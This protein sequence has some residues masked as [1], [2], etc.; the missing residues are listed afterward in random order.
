MSLTELATKIFDDLGAP[1]DTSEAAILSWL[2]TSLGKLN[3][4][5][6][7]DYVVEGGDASP[8]LGDEEAMLYQSVYLIAYYQRQ[9]SKNLGAAAYVS[10]AEVKE[11]NRTVRRTNRTEIAKTYRG[12][13]ADTQQDLSMALLAYKM[14]RS[15]P[16]DVYVSN[17]VVDESINLP[18]NVTE[19]GGN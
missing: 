5:I 1:E 2:Q 17:A 8:E 9:I 18:R 15:E 10:V 4:L 6:D 3:T 11:G 7:A 16:L 14:N 19:W 12:L 13:L